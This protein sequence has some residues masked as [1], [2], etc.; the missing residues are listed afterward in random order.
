MRESTVTDGQL[1]RQKVQLSSQCVYL[2]PQT[3]ATLN[4]NQKAIRS[5][6]R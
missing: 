3:K 6:L 5:E 4:P 1:N 2:Q